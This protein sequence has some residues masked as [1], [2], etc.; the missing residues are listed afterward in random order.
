[1]AKDSKDKATIELFD[2]LS[3]PIQTTSYVYT[4]DTNLKSQASGSETIASHQRF[5]QRQLK[6]K[7]YKINYHG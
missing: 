3:L 7:F 6:F 2:S 1:M 4:P 5:I